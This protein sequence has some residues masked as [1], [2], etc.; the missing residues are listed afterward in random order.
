MFQV[1]LIFFDYILINQIIA[2]FTFLVLGET[3]FQKV[4][5]GVFIEELGHE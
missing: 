4:Q 1:N 2:Y 3:D 5:P